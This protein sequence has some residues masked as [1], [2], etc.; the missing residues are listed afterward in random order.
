M[1]REVANVLVAMDEEEDEDAEWDG[2]EAADSTAAAQEAAEGALIERTK[3]VD[4]LTTLLDRTPR[5][6]SAAH[7][8]RRLHAAAQRV[9]LTAVSLRALSTCAAVLG[10]GFRPLLLHALYLVLAHLSS[11]HELVRTCA[12]AALAAIAFQAGY[13]SPQTLV[14][15]N[16][17][18]VV[19]VV[20]Q[21]LTYHRLSAHAPL[22]LIAMIRLVGA[23]IVPLVHDVVDEI[24]DA[25]DD[26]HGYTA[27]A[28]A[29]LAV[30]TTLIDAMADEPDPEAVEPSAA[31][32]AEREAERAAEKRVLQPPEPRK[33]FALFPKWYAERGVRAQA[34]V[35]DLLRTVPQRPWGELGEDGK[36]KAKEGKDEMDVDS[37]PADDAETPPTRTQR[38]AAQILE[39]ATFYLSHGSPFLR[40]RVLGLIARAIPVLA[41]AGREG[42]LLPVIDRAWPSILARLDDA[43]YVATAAAEAISALAGSAGAY[44]SRRIADDA[45]PRLLKLLKNQAAADARSALARRGAA[46]S[47]TE[48]AVSH[49]MY[50]ALLSTATF[51]ASEVAVKDAV[52]WDMGAAFRPLLDI[53]VHADLQAQARALYAALYMRDGDALWVLLRATTRKEGGVWAYLYDAAL[54]ITH[55]AEMILAL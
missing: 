43:P 2:A 30:L 31:K 13:A 34:Q 28:S 11:P 26:F 8:T 25:L 35:E 33:D 53:R 39:K 7:E 42:D 9:L 32:K 47:T 15:A 14:L 4:Q 3:G 46:G 10:T 50:A 51:I 55:N 20:S 18:Y 22:V 41:D 40:A 44:V 19:N 27:L 48:H 23:P 6:S 5:N 38:V 1:A 37:A 52:L 36:P 24:F 54:D 45:W 12:S 29:L 16:V 49:R 17:D 21:R